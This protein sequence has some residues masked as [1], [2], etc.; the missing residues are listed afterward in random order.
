MVPPESSDDL[1]ESHE[2]CVVWLDP[3]LAFQYVAVSRNPRALYVYEPARG[4]VELGPVQ[5]VPLG[6]IHIGSF[7]STFQVIASAE[8][9]PVAEVPVMSPELLYDS[10][11]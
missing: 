1:A 4:S 2:Y 9:Y 8:P 10:L 3:R 6:L 11:S 5:V 7:E